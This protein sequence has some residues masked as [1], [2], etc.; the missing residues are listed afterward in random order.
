MH[1]RLHSVQDLFKGNVAVVHEGHH[2]IVTQ[3]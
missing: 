2:A 1:M 3:A